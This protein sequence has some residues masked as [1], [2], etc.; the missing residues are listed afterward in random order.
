MKAVGD[1]VSGSFDFIRKINLLSRH[2]GVC[3]EA[4]LRNGCGH[5]CGNEVTQARACFRKDAV[6]ASSNRIAVLLS[7]LRV[8]LRVVPG[9]ELLPR[10]VLRLD[11]RDLDRIWRFAM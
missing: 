5:V 11:L 10:R 1:S 9:G 8:A 6:L 3:H 7:D 2:L 4:R